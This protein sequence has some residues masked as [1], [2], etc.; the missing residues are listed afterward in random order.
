[1]MVWSVNGVFLSLNSGTTWSAGFNF[2]TIPRYSS[3]ISKDGSIFF[4]VPYTQGSPIGATSLYYVS[5]TTL[6]S[7]IAS[8]WSSISIGT[9]IDFSVGSDTLASNLNGS[10]IY[11]GAA[12]SGAVTAT[13]KSNISKI[14]GS[15][16]S[17]SV[18][19]ITFDS[20]VDGSNNYC[21]N[22]ECSSDG[23]TVVI[24]GGPSSSQSTFYYISLNAGS[25]WTRYTLPVMTA[26]TIM[27]CTCSPDGKNV[28]INGN[29]NGNQRYGSYSV[30]IGYAGIKTTFTTTT[31]TQTGLASTT[32]YDVTITGNLSG[33]NTNT[34]YTGSVTTL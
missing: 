1:M 9:N 25:T 17:Y 7:N 34:L 11:A 31:Y 6:Q 8:G 30:R 27:N 24:I 10:I 15:P 19:T 32:S 2:S 23:N 13:P 22:I 20:S 3:S 12:Y 26:T 4:L 29:T 16:G 18:T 33:N 28:Y 14:T 5:R 21:Q